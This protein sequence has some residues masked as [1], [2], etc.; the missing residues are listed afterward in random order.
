[1]PEKANLKRGRFYLTQ[2]F[3]A[4]VHSCLA[5][6]SVNLLQVDQSP[7]PCS[8]LERKEKDKNGDGDGVP[9]PFED[10]SPVTSLPSNRPAS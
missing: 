1:M 10:M 6:L 9:M 2:I 7:S 3:R 4:L 8:G 5:L